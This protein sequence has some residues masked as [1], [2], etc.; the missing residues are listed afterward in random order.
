MRSGQALALLVVALFTIGV[1]MV[2]SA[3]LDLRLDPAMAMDVQEDGTATGF[4]VSFERVL[5]GRYIQLALVAITA[6]VLTAW[7]VPR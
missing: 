6:M 3:S 1:V 4:S 7:L 2:N 5:M